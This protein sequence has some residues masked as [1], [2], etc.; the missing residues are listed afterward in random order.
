MFVLLGDSPDKAA[1]EAADVMRIETALA[2]GSMDRVAMRDPDKR[3]HIM[4]IDQV[5]ALS[6]DFNWHVYLSGI[7]VGQAPS[8]NVSSP[9]FV[10]TVNNEIDAESLDALKS[11]FRWH[12]LHGARATA[13]SSGSL[14]MRTSTSFRRR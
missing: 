6:P 12:I 1:T 5:Q 7:G 2:T 10:T 8:L 9:Q 14:W 3:Y 4:T 11:Y 13:L